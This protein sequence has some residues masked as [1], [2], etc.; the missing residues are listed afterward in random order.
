MT[1]D[2]LIAALSA[3]PAAQRAMPIVQHDGRGGYGDVTA[4]APIALHGPGA[5]GKT[6]MALQRGRFGI[7]KGTGARRWRVVQFVDTRAIAGVQSVP[8]F[9]YATEPLA[10]QAEAAAAV[11]RFRKGAR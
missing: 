8:E 10:T 1:G 4:L 2:Q 3:L 6:M 7:V 11:R 9:V 5:R